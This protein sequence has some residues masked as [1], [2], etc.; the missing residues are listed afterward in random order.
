MMM[1]AYPRISHIT[2]SHKW[3]FPLEESGYKQCTVC[4]WKMKLWQSLLPTYLEKL[5]QGGKNPKSNIL[6]FPHMLNPKLFSLAGQ[7]TPTEKGNV[8]R[9]CSLWG[10]VHHGRR[11]LVVEAGGSCP[12]EFSVRKQREMNASTQLSS[13]PA[14][15]QSRTLACG[16][17]LPTFWVSLPTSAEKVSHR[18]GQRFT[19]TMTL[20]PIKLTTK[21]K[22]NIF[23]IY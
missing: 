12:A 3:V 23:H 15:I 17:V 11:G 16:I 21:S 8:K 4:K 13:A 7:N 14:F 2:L 19:S 5:N 18:N 20:H 1:N 10:I 6:I 9:N 22:Y